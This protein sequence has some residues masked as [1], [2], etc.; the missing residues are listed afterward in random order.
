MYQE[1]IKDKRHLTISNKKQNDELIKLK[2]S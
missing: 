2:K 1:A